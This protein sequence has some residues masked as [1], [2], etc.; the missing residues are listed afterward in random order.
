MAACTAITGAATT[1]RSLTLRRWAISVLHRG[2]QLGALR[3]RLLD[4]LQ[5]A[6]GLAA[7]TAGSGEL[8]VFL[9]Q[10][11]DSIVEFQVLDTL[12]DRVL[13]AQQLRQPVILTI[14]GAG[15]GLSSGH[16]T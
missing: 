8:I 14:T 16:T 4:L 15:P 13:A 10:L 11:A 9:A 2:I 5:Q 12:H 1:G 6:D 7:Q 3:R